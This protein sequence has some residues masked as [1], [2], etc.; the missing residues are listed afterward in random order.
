M[1]RGDTK[2]NE[3]ENLRS[4]INNYS[5]ILSSKW[6][7]GWMVVSQAGHWRKL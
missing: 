5:F 1:E 6:S 4:S 3:G 2:K 7:W